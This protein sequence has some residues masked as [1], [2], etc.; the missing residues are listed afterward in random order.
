MAV[1]FAGRPLTLK[2]A[3]ADFRIAVPPLPDRSLPTHPTQVY[4]TINAFL[5]CLLTL[6]VFP[7]RRRD[8]EVFLFLIA[9]YAVTRFLLEVIRTDELG[10]WSTGMTI[11]QNVSV[12]MLIGVAV[13]VAWMWKQPKASFWP[14]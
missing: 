4:S 10:V 13:A 1:E 14:T 11:S 9:M 8:G 12:A 5:L 7:F 2:T 6:A 3:E